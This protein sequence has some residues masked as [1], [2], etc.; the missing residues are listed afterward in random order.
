[1]R[2]SPVSSPPWTR[3]WRSCDEPATCRTGGA[4]RLRRLSRLGTARPPADAVGRTPGATRRRAARAS[5]SGAG[6]RKQYL[7][8]GRTARGSLAFHGVQRRAAAA[9]S[10]GGVAGASRWPQ[11]RGAGKARRSGL[12]WPAG[13]VQAPVAI[14]QQRH[15]RRVA[16]DA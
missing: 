5:P 16:A 2:T 1:A 11:R 10:A 7:A 3:R 14:T 4:G 15:E 6:L 12:V 13:P 8:A 9:R